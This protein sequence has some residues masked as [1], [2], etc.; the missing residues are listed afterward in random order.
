MRQ[1]FLLGLFRLTRYYA[2]AILIIFLSLAILSLYYLRDLPIDSSLTRLLPTEDLTVQKLRAQ[3]EVLADTD[4]ITAVLTLTSPPPSPN[5]GKERLLAAA[6]QIVLRLQDHEEIRKVDYTQQD[7]SKF[8]PPIDATRLEEIGG[9]MDAAIAQLEVLG[10]TDI[11]LENS[12]RS[13]PER[14]GE[15]AAG[16]EGLFSGWATFLGDPDIFTESIIALDLAKKENSNFLSFLESIPGNFAILRNGIDAL[17]GELDNL[18]GADLSTS[19]FEDLSIS[20]DQRSLLVT[21]APRDTS[22]KGIEYNTA[23]TQIVEDALA[24]IDFVQYGVRVV[25]LVGPYIFSAE[26]DEALKRDTSRTAIITIIGVL[27]L[28]ILVLRRYFYPLL[29]TFPVL[30]A[31]IFTIAIARMMFG[32][33][34]LVTAFLPAIILGLGIDYGIQFIVHYLEERQGSRRL[35]PALRST[36][37]TKGSAMISAAF[38]TSLV[39]FALGFVAQTVGLS[40]IGY[41]LA[42]GVLLSCFLTLI[43]LPALIFAISTVMGRRVRAQPPKPWNLMPFAQFVVK[44]R[45]IVIGLTLVGSIFMF[46]PAQ[47]VSFSFVS[48]ALE[49]TSLQSSRVG[50]FIEA[51]FEEGPNRG[52]TFLFF[53]DPDQAKRVFEALET[54]VPGVD[55]VYSLYRWVEDPDEVGATLEKIRELIPKIHSIILGL[56]DVR[57]LLANTQFQ[58]GD[59]DSLKTALEA[60]IVVLQDGQN[61]IELATPDRGLAQMIEEFREKVQDILATIT[62]LEEQNIDDQISE[63]IVELD[64]VKQKLQIVERQIARVDELEVEYE[65]ARQYFET[66]DIETGEPQQLIYVQVKIEVLWN[67]ALYD[68]FLTRSAGIWDDFIGLAMLRVLLEFYMEQDFW[69]STIIAVIIISLILFFDFLATR[70]RD[71]K[72]IKVIG[73]TVFSLLSLGLGYLWLLGVMGLRG[74][75]FNVANILI[76]P[77]LLG[78]GVDNCV[79]LL[80]RYQDMKAQKMAEDS[81]LP[82]PY[83]RRATASTGVPIIANTLATMIAFGSLLI[84]E[85]PLLRILGETAVVGIGFMTLFSLTFLP[86]IVALRR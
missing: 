71:V 65:N 42:V 19:S 81:A 30:I 61:Q 46:F 86:S 72:F 22:Q 41:I 2:W 80:R 28:F 64:V 1:R 35:A 82:N 49:P 37:L 10:Q 23:V 32:G 74:I 55:N 4:V 56:D 20:E 79:Y 34:N 47:L 76:S 85:T 58:F 29:A 50:E 69:K 75:D 33:L 26:S 40:E 77:L 66:T 48:E 63:L 8:S 36:M 45:W 7:L 18:Q 54:D 43:L 27:L 9:Y 21:I 17:N 25:G 14:Y 5:E 83:I 73:L 62:S 68:E 12:E 70:A 39:M 24:S 13:P 51:N 3:Q 38:A 84:A 11:P 6:D 52:N 15:A 59:R 78:L 44:A 57:D 60:L 67:S 31:L 16:L 53:V